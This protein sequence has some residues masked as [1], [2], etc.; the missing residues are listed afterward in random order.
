MWAV[1][2]EGVGAGIAGLVERSDLD[3]PGIRIM[4]GSVAQGRGLRLPLMG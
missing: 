3:A 1:R 4:L 2:L